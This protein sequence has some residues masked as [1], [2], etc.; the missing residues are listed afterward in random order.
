[1]KLV[2]FYRSLWVGRSMN[3]HI[4]QTNA[5]MP[6]MLYTMLLAMVAGPNINATKSKP[7][8]PIS[9]QF[10]APMIV[11]GINTY[12]VSPLISCFSFSK[13]YI[14][15]IGICPA[16]NAIIASL[17]CACNCNTAIGKRFLGPNLCGF[18]WLV[19]VCI[20]VFADYDFIMFLIQ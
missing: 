20:A 10:K 5:A 13:V 16:D 18:Y 6:I 3:I 17:Y 15:P 8:I 4:T 1:M 9:P 19:R 14:V 11:N 7:K 2:V 12:V